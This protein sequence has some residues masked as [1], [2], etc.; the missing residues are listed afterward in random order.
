MFVGEERQKKNNPS[1]HAITTADTT[2]MNSNKNIPF[3]VLHLSDDKVKAL[4]VV[5]SSMAKSLIKHP[6][7]CR[8][9]SFDLTIDVVSQSRARNTA[10]ENSGTTFLA[11]EFSSPQPEETARAIAERISIRQENPSPNVAHLFG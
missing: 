6:I 1:P 8:G 9:A 2:T 11:T 3:F 7:L 5:P 4:F 10:V